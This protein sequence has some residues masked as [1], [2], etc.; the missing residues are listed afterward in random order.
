MCWDLFIIYLPL[1]IYSCA[2]LVVIPLLFD[3]LQL[4]KGLGDVDNECCSAHA[5]VA[6]TGMHVGMTFSYDP[7]LKHLRNVVLE[8]IY[9]S[10][11]GEGGLEECIRD[12][13]VHPSENGY[14][15]AVK[16]C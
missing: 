12:A 15:S 8:H 13:L 14:T 9:K 3:M 5:G 10:L 11:K 1:C 16:V 4:T 2:I 7:S 6:G